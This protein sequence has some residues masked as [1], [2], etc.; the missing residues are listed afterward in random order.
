MSDV[1]GA[2]PMPGAVQSCTMP[3]HDDA[4][5]HYDAVH[6]LSWPGGSGR[7]LTEPTSDVPTGEV[8][9]SPNG[10]DLAIRN[11]DDR[12]FPWRVTDG[13][14]RADSQVAGWQPYPPPPVPTD[15]L[16]IDGDLAHRLADDAIGLFLEAVGDPEGGIC[17]GADEVATAASA[18]VREVVEGATTV[19]PADPI[20]RLRAIAE[21]AVTARLRYSY[22]AAI[23][24]CEQ[25]EDG[26]V[27]ITL[28]SGGNA[29]AVAEALAVAGIEHEDTGG[30]MLRVSAEALENA[31]AP[32]PADIAEVLRQVVLDWVPEDL[33][34]HEQPCACSGHRARRMLALL[35]VN[36]V[37]DWPADRHAVTGR[38]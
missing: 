36:A 5:G 8:R 9:L 16:P 35:G 3:P 7:I 18:A 14:Q 24:S 23:V 12:H 28:N 25:V 20:K 29:C 15:R 13:S 30:K 11:R 31:A 34:P 10:R 22:P 1:C 19:L 32:Q 2:R 17:V 6:N 26:S 33:E 21:R 37:P 38:D 27:G 4:D